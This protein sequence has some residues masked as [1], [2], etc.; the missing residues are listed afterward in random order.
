[1]LECLLNW[2]NIIRAACKLIRSVSDVIFET[3]GRAQL[4]SVLKVSIWIDDN[5]ELSLTGTKSHLTN[6]FLASNRNRM[7][8]PNEKISDFFP[9]FSKHSGLANIGVPPFESGSANPKSVKTISIWVSSARPFLNFTKKFCGLISLWVWLW[10]S[11]V[12]RLWIGYKQKKDSR[13]R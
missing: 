8:L 7:T 5:R 3:N 11:S 9:F 4:N 2:S 10:R 12:S 1:M 13:L 6:R